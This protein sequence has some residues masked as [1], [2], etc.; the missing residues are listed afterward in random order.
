MRRLSLPLVFAGVSFLH[1]C[2]GVVQITGHSDALREGGTVV[3]CYPTKTLPNISNLSIAPWQ[4][5]LFGQHV[6]PD[7]AGRFSANIPIRRASD[8]IIVSGPYFEHVTVDKGDS[9]H[10]A[11]RQGDSAMRITGR[12]KALADVAGYYDDQVARELRDSIHRVYDELHLLHCG[13]FSPNWLDYRDTIYIDSILLLRD[14]RIA[15]ESKLLERFGAPKFA[16]ERRARS[17]RR[18]EVAR[19]YNDSRCDCVGGV[20]PQLYNAS[21]LPKKDQ[22]LAWYYSALED[23]ENFKRVQ[24]YNKA[25][26]PESERM[27]YTPPKIKAARDNIVAA[28]NL[29]RSGNGDLLYDSLQFAKKFSDYTALAGENHPAV[30]FHRMAF[31]ARMAWVREPY[32]RF[33]YLETPQ[34]LDSL[35]T[36][37]KATAPR[38]YVV[39][40]WLQEDDGF[41]RNVLPLARAERALEDKGVQSLYLPFYEDESTAAHALHQLGLRAPFATISEASRAHL[42]RLLGGTPL[43]QSRCLLFDGEGRFVTAELPPSSEAEGLAEAVERALKGR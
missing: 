24:H 6:E 32:S 11:W 2:T 20:L 9:L 19:M 3:V 16:L 31:E 33:V 41:I 1:S 10:F 38:G 25:Q 5:P 12:Q 18:H 37:Y 14:R 15:L 8:I 23:W 40:L 17:I 21:D 30:Q 27:W 28:S 34:P 4:Y 35:F 42:L 22:A 13:S 43:R 36:Q 29:V 26:T 39:W 7:S